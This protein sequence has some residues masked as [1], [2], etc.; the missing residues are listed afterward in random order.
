[1]IKF[2]RNLFRPILH[3]G[4]EKLPNISSLP[5]YQDL[6][7]MNSTYS[8]RDFGISRAKFIVKQNSLSLQDFSKNLFRRHLGPGFFPI[9]DHLASNP[10]R[11]SKIS[12]TTVTPLIC[13]CISDS[14]DGFKI[15][16]FRFDLLF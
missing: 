10:D 11:Q 2:G 15:K 12:E 3:M 14:Q 4:L 5:E 7:S 1:M 6:I 9:F 16:R 8:C 13:F